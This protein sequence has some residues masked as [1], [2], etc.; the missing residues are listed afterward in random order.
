[1]SINREL[2]QLASFLDVHESNNFIGIATDGT[3]TVGIGTSSVLIGPTGIITAKQFV[4]PTGQ[5]L[6][7][8]IELQNDGSPVGTGF[9][10]VNFVG[11]GVT[12]T[13]GASGIATVTVVGTAIVGTA[14][15]IDATDNGDGTTT[16]S[17]PNQVAITSSLTVGTVKIESGIITAT[18]GIVTYN[19]DGSGL[20]NINASSLTGIATDSDK[21]DGQ[22][23]T[24]YLDYSNFSGIATDSDKLDGQEGTYY[25]DYSNFSGIA[26]DSSLLDGLDST[27][28]LRSDV[29]DIKT[30]G[31]LTF[32]DN[33]QARF[34]TNAELKVYHTG[35]KG[36]ITNSAV[37]N[38]VIQN[39]VDDYDIVINCDDGSGATTEYFRADGSSGEA[40][41]SHYGSLKLATK[42]NGIDV[43]G[44]TETD[45]LNASGIIT[46]SSFDGN[47]NALG[48]TYYVATTGSD[49]NS[50]TNINEPYLTI[51]KA[52]TVASSGD[53]IN[54]SAG[55]YAETCPLVVPA[56]VTVKGAGL[57]AT[58]IKPTTA[59]QTENIFHLDNLTTL[60][61]FT[62]KDS[63]YNTNADTGYAFAY[64]PNITISSRS[65]Y[66]QRV[67]V[68]NKGSVVTTDD[69]YGYDT[70]DSPPTSYI[71]GRG[72]L[73]D[74]RHV[75]ADSLE[76]G[77][78]FN[79]VTFFTPNN[80]GIVITNGGRVEYLNCFHYFAS[81]GIVG[82]AG[83]VGIAGTADARLK[84][85]SANVTPSVNDVVKL[86]EG[87][88]Q[89]AIGTI[90]EWNSPY[91]KIDGKGSGTFT[92][93]G[94]GT[95]QDVRF[96]QS[97]GTT[98]T[99]IASAID[100]ADYKMFGADLRS[101]GCA[102]EYG[103]QG[104]VADGVGTELRLFGIN[105]NH[106]GSGKDFTNDKTLTIQANET[107]ELNDGQVSY[108][109]VDQDGDFRVGEIFFI[110]QE[111]GNVSFAATTFDLEVTGNMNV[112][113]GSNTTT[114]TPTSLTVGNL[115]LAANTFSSTNGDIIID[116]A[117]SN[118]TTV[119]GNLEVT[120][121][122][123]A[124]VFEASAIQQGDTSISLTDTGSNGTIKVFTDNVEAMRVNSSQNV[125]I[126]STQPTAKLDVNGTL[127]VT[128]I[129]TFQGNVFLGDNDELTFGDGTDLII[130]SN[131]TNAQIR[132]SGGANINYRSTT[133]NFRNQGGT[134][135]LAT[136]TAGGSVEL[137]YADSKKFETV[138]GGVSVSSGT[139]STATIYGPG[140]LIIDP[141]PVDD[142]GGIVRIK[143]DLYVDGTTTEINST[144]LTVDDLNVV[145]AS[146]ATNGLTADGAGL[147][148]AGAGATIKYNYNGGSEQ[149]V[150]N[151]APY[152]NTNRLLTTADEGSGNGIDAD[153]L[154]GQ[155]GTYYLD[156]ANFSGTASELN[157][158]GISTLGTVQISSGIITA[159][160]GIVTYFGDGSGLSNVP[161]SSLSGLSTDSD[162]LDGQE[163]TYYLD[164][165]NFV[166]VATDSDKLD[167]IQASSFL[168]SDEADT[169][170]GITT[171]QDNANF[172]SNVYLGDS[173]ILWF[174]DGVNPGV[175][176]D[177]QI[178]S[179]GTTSYIEERT[180]AL[181]IYSNDL[182]LQDYS[183]AKIYLR[184]QASGSVQL[185]HNNSQK[186]ETTNGGV[187]IT[188][189][190]TATTF[191]GS[192]AS[193]TDIPTSALVGLATDADKLDGQEGTYYL[194]Y[195]N[196]SGIA[197]DSDKLDGQQGTYYLDYANFSGIATDSSLLDGL[198]ST[199]FLRSDAADTASGLLTLTNGLNVTSGDVGIGTDNPSD[200]LH[201]YGDG[202]AIFG[203]GS[204]YGKFL[205]IG[206]DSSAAPSS[207]TANIEVTNGNLHIDAA[208]G[209]FGVFLNY[210]GGTAG[211]LFGNG[212]NGSVGKFH[213]DGSLTVN[214]T[215]VTGTPSQKLNVNGGAHLSGDVGIGTDAPDA[216]LEVR[217]DNS[218]GIIVRSNSTQ[219]TDTNK[220]LRV[221]NNSDTNTFHV[222]HRGQGYFAG[223]VGIGTDSPEEDL[224]IG[225]NS[226]YILL[227]DYDN[228]RKWKLKGTAWFA[229]EDTTAG[230]DRLRIL[231]N[232]N[233]GI[234]TN[235]PLAKLDVRDGS[236][237]VPGGTFDAS[238]LGTGNDSKTDAALVI[239][240][241]SEIYTQ[242]GGYLRTLIG[243]SGFIINI[244]QQNTSL[245]SEINLKPGNASS[246][247]VKLHHGGTG[248][249]VKLTTTGYG[250]TIT[251]GIN[252]SGVATATDFN[253]ASDENLKTN[254]RTIEDPLAKV[255]QIRGV[256]FDWK[257]T[258]R[259]SLGVIAQEVE[260]VLPE[261]VTD[262]GTKTVNYNGLIGLLIETVKEQQKQIN[263]L[264][265]RL[266]KLE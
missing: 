118:E 178:K 131:G 149:W 48:N 89:V 3:Y 38:L 246:N 151:K 159:T 103:A 110:D 231:S 162:K 253:S 167:G 190:A 217:D 146:G 163:G 94:V 201:V 31:H 111:T 92:S 180:S 20:T 193:L 227:D 239:D 17:L 204:T 208:E 262:N 126:G 121:I 95:T 28:F 172:Q 10:T 61:D 27:Q 229:I 36:F 18:S 137:Y 44:H 35:A 220:A 212:S 68:L 158:S 24:Y 171:F 5:D 152:Y 175:V 203:P 184:A 40:R 46:A 176:G 189:I 75:T 13:E 124:S 221:R 90:T 187:T 102:V 107:V 211:T 85:R 150:F 123:T 254:I 67:T 213:N 196:F 104:V 21:L 205:K 140:N 228:S 65:P 155:E 168:R 120:G 8:S 215:S 261:L 245:I 141:A 209:A 45:T 91:A 263:T 41:L 14:G 136:F 16:L 99:G 170:T 7:D 154:D 157:V 112:T 192:G 257:E 214:T 135:Q 25:L 259:P 183:N 15:E 81:Q 109:S 54:I 130:T 37:G 232:G 96:F 12:V 260:K 200:S 242:G 86:F 199:S 177:L 66:I 23:G 116:P 78:L 42:S 160:S 236:V 164:Y 52:L 240:R 33:I 39:N 249:N 43:T 182:Y 51:T 264:S 2:S 128:G 57:R 22:E 186:F 53:I 173:D 74:G 251:G 80:K 250:V 63:Y 166:G 93:V 79:E 77:M 252:V 134:E 174:G 49:T 219:A 139:A 195:A 11:T 87:G 26:T 223:S 265:E 113:D 19:G 258:Q 9:T 83:T 30:A 88:S 247:G 188:G 72:A 145:V 181:R 244:G 147:S 59:T 194:N 64:K 101:V 106:V 191:S 153:T 143:G 119:Q 169:K 234:G 226:P 55:E 235:N 144:T 161:T 207:S 29:A 238:S 32:N 222:S 216:K 1:M 206:A 82:V 138:G 132:A 241:G 256:N 6:I 4:G 34:G 248:D 70:A 100:F 165:A 58:A 56:G 233:I 71:A 156:Y 142:N 84:F 185:Y 230:E 69:P 97:D 76:A 224:H 105:F 73:V 148:V 197:T 179:D 115:Q 62:I 202:S 255:V 114:I 117:G 47:L 50:G 210:Y 237:Y 225:S 243:S 198:D 125:G 129:A 127:N 60:E 98:Q 133:H 122:L 218:T 266:S 108:V